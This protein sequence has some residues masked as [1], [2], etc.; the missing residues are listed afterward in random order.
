MF[1]R[2]CGNQLPDDAK[3]CSKC[4][5]S[6]TETKPIIHEAEP[7]KS[8]ITEQEAPKIVEIPKEPTSKID[9]AT[10]SKLDKELNKPH[11]PASVL[12]IV[13]I[14]CGCFCG[15]I[16]LFTIFSA[17]ANN[18]KVENKKTSNTNN[19]KVEENVQPTPKPE[20][21]PEP[22][23][24]GVADPREPSTWI[25]CTGEEEWYEAAMYVGEDFNYDEW[26]YYEARLENNYDES[27]ELR[28]L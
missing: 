1:C 14:I 27:G 8:E 12:K 2:Y 28:K 24:I 21:K 3:F 26:V 10:A 17:I 15:V 23:E 20:P 6:V 7:S 4:G 18:S 22:K 13:G 5:N 11:N 9:W 25:Y 19:T 16:L